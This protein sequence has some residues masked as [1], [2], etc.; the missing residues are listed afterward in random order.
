MPPEKEPEMATSSTAKYQ[1]IAA[2]RD[3]NDV[4]IGP[5]VMRLATAVNTI[6]AHRVDA[7][8]EN[9]ETGETVVTGTWVQDSL[10]LEGAPEVMEAIKNNLLE[11]FTDGRRSRRDDAGPVNLPAVPVTTGRH[12]GARGQTVAETSDE[13]YARDESLGERTSRRLRENRKDGRA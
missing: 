6:T 10:T 3:G 1:A 13:R 11:G 4:K 2:D 12:V 8:I 9:T 7:R 5:R